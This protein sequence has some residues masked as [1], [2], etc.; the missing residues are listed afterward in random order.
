MVVAAICLLAHYHYRMN[1]SDIRWEYKLEL[2]IPPAAANSCYARMR[3]S[4][5]IVMQV[6]DEN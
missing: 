5:V 1:N 2:A 6:E 4:G 3:L